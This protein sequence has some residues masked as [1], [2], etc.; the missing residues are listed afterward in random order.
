[1][2]SIA[3]LTPKGETT[4]AH[5][6]QT[7]AGLFWR[8]SYHGVSMDELARAA[9]VNKATIYRYFPTKADLAEA[10][11]RRAGDRAITCI[12]EPAFREDDTPVGR[13]DGIYGRF[14]AAHRSVYDEEGD[15]YGCPI[16]G[17]AVEVGT[18][19]PQI[20]TV[21]SEIFARVE[22]FY[23]AIADAAIADGGGVGW[24]VE[25]LARTLVQLQHGALVATRVE[26]RPQP[27]REA[28]D[29]SKRLIS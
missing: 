12:F 19:M 8:R 18:D 7:A 26:A 22:A 28:A 25:T 11:I 23:W 4:A 2:S 6:R 17:L 1:M 24:N 29:A 20:R 9:E 21:A 13:L 5:I 15:M 14:L 27:L 3:I 10:V 16:A